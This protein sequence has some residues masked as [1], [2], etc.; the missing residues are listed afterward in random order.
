MS[1]RVLIS[2]QAFPPMTTGS[3]M[4]LYEL[5]KHLPQDELVAVHGIGDPPLLNGPSL[6]MERHR[7]L[8]LG[9]YAWTVRFERRCP[10]YYVP[11][12]RRCLKRWAKEHSV[13]R[14][15]AHFPSSSFLVAACQVAEELDLPL[16]VYFDILW[17]ELP[18]CHMRMA[19]K[20]ERRVL[21][22]ADSRF[23]ITEFAA[24][25]L[26]KKHGLPVGFLPHT[27]DLANKADG[28][29]AIPDDIRPTIHFCGGIYPVMN[30]DAIVRLVDAVQR[31]RATRKSTFALRACRR[32]C[33]SEAYSPGICGERTCE[34][35][36]AKARSNSFPRPS[37]HVAP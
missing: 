10:Q 14:I 1:K 29:Q 5:L 4:I 6:G 18:E 31:A 34:L 23:A 36:N 11:L 35:H 13:Q 7:A 21:E 27:I 16:T 25:F 24:D 37:I 12:I 33:G 30:Q 17:G 15:Y 20:Y 8:V 28:F 19:R 2:T 32:N 26:V 22:R 3:S 9:S